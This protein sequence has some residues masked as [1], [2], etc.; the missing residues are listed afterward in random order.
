MAFYF[1]ITAPYPGGQSAPYTPRFEPLNPFNDGTT[2]QGAGQGIPPRIINWYD[3]IPKDQE[4]AFNTL[5]SRLKDLA[6]SLDA[7]KG[8][9]EKYNRIASRHSSFLH[10]YNANINSL[11]HIKK[12]RQDS[13]TTAKR[14]KELIRQEEEKK[15]RLS[16]ELRLFFD[17]QEKEYDKQENIFQ[18]LFKRKEFKALD[19]FLTNPYAILPK[20]VIFEYYNPG[21]NNYN[22]LN[23]FNPMDGI[24]NQFTI[25]TLNQLNNNSFQRS[26]AGGAD[27]NYFAP[28][29]FS[30]ALSVEQIVFSFE[31]SVKIRQAWAF[32]LQN[33]WYSNGLKLKIIAAKIKTTKVLEDLQESIREKERELEDERRKQDANE[34]NIK[35]LT[36]QILEKS[37]ELQNIKERLAQ[38]YRIVKEFTDKKQSILNEINHSN[39][40]E[41]LKHGFRNILNN[42]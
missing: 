9:L 28:L 21:S 26:L 10:D 2:G 4:N 37:K 16:K 23:A 41:N 18:G 34:E 39:L 3:I 40:N 42:F 15:Q 19:V 13:F 32:F 8:A 29:N 30:K 17:F 36:G 25:N 22:P 35:A 5:G 14:L 33:K 6:G 11:E 27:F 12:E 20:G 31:N 1:D 38:E 24:N 7:Y